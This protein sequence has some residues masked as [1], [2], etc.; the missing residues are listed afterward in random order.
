MPAQA[1]IAAVESRAS[2]IHDAAA[3]EDALNR[4]AGAITAKPGQSDPVLLCVMHG[5]LIATSE[6]ALRLRF[7]LQI[8]YLHMS[9]YRG[10]TSGGKIERIA[11][12][13][14]DLRG[15]VVLVVDDILDEGRTLAAA[16]GYCREQGASQVWLAALVEKRLPRREALIEADFIGL[17]VPNRYVYGYGMDYHGYLRN[18]KGIYAIAEQDV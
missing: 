12:P 4:M 1:E 5:G 13:S 14:V 6:L 8:D 17:S 10:S 2:C 9:R 3:V 7:P 16:S 18:A 11:M 15:R